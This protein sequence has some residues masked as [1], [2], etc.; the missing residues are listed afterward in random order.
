[1]ECKFCRFGLGFDMRG[2]IPLAFRMGA[3][4]AVREGM[5]SAGCQTSRGSSTLG[6]DV[7][8]QEVGVEGGL[9]VNLAPAR[10]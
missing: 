10:C 8:R 4:D 3:G 6:V 7:L 1:M 2:N 5:T 9:Y